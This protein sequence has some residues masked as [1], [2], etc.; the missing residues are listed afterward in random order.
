[1]TIRPLVAAT[2]MGFALVS[3]ARAEEKTIVGVAA[4]NDSF[5]TLVA[6]VKAAGLVEA[7][8]DVLG[9]AAIDRVARRDAEEAGDGGVQVDRAEV[10]DVA[11]LGD[12]GAP[13]VE[14]QI[15]RAHV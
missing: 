3:L 14:E 5:K 2:L 4:G 7:R 10:A 12:P 1:M 9:H 11:P 8:E 13:G 6:A 15:G